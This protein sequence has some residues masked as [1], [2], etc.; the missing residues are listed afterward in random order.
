MK[1]LIAISSCQ[2]Y[3]VSGLNTPMRETWL[4]D[5]EAIGVDHKF[6]HGRGTTAKDIVVINCEDTYMGLID[7]FRAKIKWA[8]DRDYDFVFTCLAD[9]YARPERLLAACPRTYFGSVYTHETYG[10]YCQGGAGFILSK[11]ACSVLVKDN[12]PLRH[13]DGTM[14]DYWS[15]DAWAG[16]ALLRAGITPEHSEDFK[17]WMPHGRPLKNNS[18]ITCHLSYVEGDMG[19]KPERMYLEHEDWLKSVTKPPETEGLVQKN[20]PRSM[21]WTRRTT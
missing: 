11:E 16:Q 6:F 9:C 4:P 19:Y 14:G 12:L 13:R 3:E 2:V 17:V 8:L 18:I 20:T 7:K 21:R 15:E 1:L 10:S 5:A